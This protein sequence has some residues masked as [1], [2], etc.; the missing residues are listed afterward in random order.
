MARLTRE[1]QEVYLNLIRELHDGATKELSLWEVDFLNSID[2]QI[3]A[4]GTLTDK[5]KVRLNKLYEEKI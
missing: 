4:Y 2:N 5:Q 3:T 1:E